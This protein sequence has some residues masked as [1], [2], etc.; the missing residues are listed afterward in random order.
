MK[1]KPKYVLIGV[2]IA[3]TTFI[4]CILTYSIK[5][6]DL[7][8]I[9]V[10]DARWSIGTY[11][12]HHNG[13][14][15]SAKQITASNNPIL[16]VEDI[17]DLKDAHYVADPFLI[18]KNDVFYLFFEILRSNNGD[19][20]LATSRD[21]INW[22]Y[23][24]IVLDESFHLSYPCVFRWKD[25]FYMIP[26]SHQEK[27]IRLYIADEF[28]FKWRLVK[29]LFEG[30]KFLD[31]TIFRY[32]GIW[33]IFSSIGDNNLH[34]YFSK[35][36]QGTWM[37]HPMSPV[38]IDDPNIARPGG[39][40]IQ[41]KDQLIRIAQD[42]FPSYGDAVRAFS[43]TK[44]SIEEYEEKELEDSP[45]FSG[46]GKGWNSEGMHQLS[47]QPIET[48]S[49]LA[50]VDGKHK[51]RE[52]YIFFGSFKIPISSEKLQWIYSMKRTIFNLAK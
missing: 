29:P 30:Q 24:G 8:Y 42:D 13:S 9:G 27:A 3:F 25:N 12:V 26:E 51:I 31:P 47:M 35:D 14:G 33:W 15:F 45:L 20:G 37:E 28:P 23:R 50:V 7:P 4:I 19:I 10:I 17:T 16:K 6:K 46:S 32:N 18:R 38:I 11:I 48:N 2:L 39:N 52:P 21:G 36:L 43:I 40:V 44:L 1:F 5:K 49:W 34:L 41:F 22:Q